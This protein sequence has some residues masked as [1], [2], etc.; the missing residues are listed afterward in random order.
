MRIEDVLSALGTGVWRWDGT[1]DVVEL[2]AVSAGLMGL[3]RRPQKVH[4]GTVRACYD[5]SD[6]VDMSAAV[7]LASAEGTPS[8]SFLRVVGQDGSII[9]TVAMRSCGVHCGA[10]GQP[11]EMAGTL[12][13]E[14]AAGA[15]APAPADR[16]RAREAFL[17]DAGRALAEA[18]STQEVL[19]VAAHLSMPGFSPDGLAVF[20]L[21]GDHLSVIGHHGQQP[22]A[23]TPFVEMPHLRTP[24]EMASSGR[25]LLLVQGLA[26]A[27]GVD[28]LGDGKSIW[29][30]L[31]EAPTA[32]TAG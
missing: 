16:R 17:L 19:R 23:E 10:G 8:E 12:H 13:E 27:W 24:G 2:D 9:R 32:P 11:G 21:H 29:F 25:G 30:E 15:A 26:D 20:G 18:D 14:P 6:Y 5:A 4:S 3:A 1:T 28:P 31:Y 22:G 7:A